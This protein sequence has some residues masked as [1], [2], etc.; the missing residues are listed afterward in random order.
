MASSKTL[1]QA[2]ADITIWRKGEQRAPHKPLLLLYVLANYQHGHARLFDYGTEVHEQLLSLLERFGPQ[3]KTHYPNMPFWRLRGD[4]F[5]DLKNTEF[6][7]TTGSK[8]PPVKELVEH[9]VAGGFDEEHFAL[10][11]KNKNL[12]GSLAQQILEAHFPESIQEEIADE[13]G[14]DIQQIRKVRDPLFR[15]QVMRAYNYECAI[16][17]FNMRHDNTSVGLEAAHIKWKQFGGPCEIPNGLALCA[18]HHKAF[19]KG[20]IGLD[21]SMRVLVS[22]AVNGNGNVGRLFW[23]FAGK[24][25]ALPVVKGNYPREGFVE[26][27]RREVFKHNV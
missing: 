26:W 2:I 5:W 27:H 10:L 3:R 25:I 12:I 22:E 9:N 1:E 18:I 7:S 24:Q 19:D 20:S 6:C 11:S 16:C 8:Q 4:G 17:G 14:F 13:M 21:E 15:Q 23:D